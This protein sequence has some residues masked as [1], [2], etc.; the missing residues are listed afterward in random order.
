MA[1]MYV[2]SSLIGQML[3]VVSAMDPMK[4]IINNSRVRSFATRITHDQLRSM[5]YW[6]NVGSNDEADH[7]KTV[8]QMRQCIKPVAQLISMYKYM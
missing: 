1:V 5:T 8:G 2:T 4:W 7:A 6:S 3:S